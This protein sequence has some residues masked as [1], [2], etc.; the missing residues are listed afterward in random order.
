MGEFR[1][2]VRSALR[3]WPL[4]VLLI[5]AAVVGMTAVTAAFAFAHGI[6]LSPLP[7]SDPDQLITYGGPGSQLLTV[8]LPDFEYWQEGSSAIQRLAGYKV[9]PRVWRRDGNAETLN[10]ADVTGAYFELLGVGTQRGRSLEPADDRPDASPAAVISDAF[11][12]GRLGGS[13]DVIGTPLTLDDSAWIVV[14]VL[15]PDTTFPGDATASVYRPIQRAFPEAVSVPFRPMV[16]V[17]A[18]L[19]KGTRPEQAQRRS[20]HLASL[21][22]DERDRPTLMRPQ[23]VPLLASIVGETEQSIEAFLALISLVLLMACA[24]AGGLLLAHSDR[25]QSEYA[26]RRAMGAGDWSVVRL[27]LLQVV[28]LV[29]AAGIITVPAAFWT[30][31]WIK[32]ILPASV[33]RVEQVGIEWTVLFAAFAIVLLAMS[34]AA[35]LPCWRFASVE[36][37]LLR[38]HQQASSNG[39]VPKT[40]AL[41]IS[42]QV[43]ATTALLIV[44]LLAAKSF[45]RVWS[46]DHGFEAKRVLTF[47]TKLPSAERTSVEPQE[48][49]RQLIQELERLPGIEAVAAASQLPL[50]GQTGRAGL[51]IEG[52]AVRPSGFSVWADVNRVS[53]GYFDVI[54][55]RLL[56]GRSF[57]WP[58][59]AGLRA[60]VVNQALA[61][62]FWP[63]QD[64]LGKR[65][66]WGTADSDTPWS[67]VEAIVPKMQYELL[68]VP[69]LPPYEPLGD[70]FQIYFPLEA[71]PEMQLSFLLRSF[72]DSERQADSVRELW[73]TINGS[74]PLNRL[75]TMG[76]IV[77]DYQEQPR[78]TAGLLL[79]IA[80]SS[81]FLSALGIYGI[82]LTTVQGRQREIALRAAV[83][84]PP[85]EIV[86][87]AT[88]YT[89][90]ATLPGLA[91]GLLLTALASQLFA[92]LLFDVR[93]VDP[94]GYVASII[95]VASANLVALIGPVRRARSLDLVGL[96]RE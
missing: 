12:K 42:G 56:R 39:V 11:W 23:A 77:A 35:V 96:L 76:S 70:G 41:L 55:S 52:A 68:G 88:G 14:G 60:V 53:P 80:I 30:I 13:E 86:R 47:E 85:H 26:I 74:L 72:S 7:F 43:A 71:H 92:P 78:L 2:V 93:A 57:T 8:S 33:P 40:R 48:F 28:Y 64:P 73:R 44:S 66:K 15:D 61:E 21:L 34:I 32:S 38:G 90:R 1:F 19:T 5:A 89:L 58:T 75:R 69:R 79:P 29:G 46:A 87:V 62:H 3:N 84:A 6:L 65:L 31:G 45:Y 49:V 25:R 63:D 37:A 9:G 24:S 36:P 18:R 16:K 27:S 22:A 51:T 81:L 91:L 50:S 95:L 83:G 54:G 17:I 82:A 10:V 94:F 67:V 20:E 59:G 4:S